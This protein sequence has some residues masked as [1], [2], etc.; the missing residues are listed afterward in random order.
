MSLTKFQRANL[1]EHIHNQGQV[2]D[3]SGVPIVVGSAAFVGCKVYATT[4][5][6]VSASTEPSI[7]PGRS[8]RAEFFGDA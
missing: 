5:Q 4:T 6:V 3:D 7:P 2:V 1:R 8:C